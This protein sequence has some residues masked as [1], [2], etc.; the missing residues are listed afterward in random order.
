ML[1]AKHMGLKI[2]IKK[3][4]ENESR[5]SFNIRPERSLVNIGIYKLKI[6]TTTKGP[7]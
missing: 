3:K 1:K 2:I 7:F 5:G 4:K 6:C